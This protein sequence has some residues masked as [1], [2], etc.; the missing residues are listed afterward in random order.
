VISN[1][2]CKQSAQ[3]P[4]LPQAVFSKPLIRD[5]IEWDQYPGRLE[6]PQVVN[7]SARVSGIIE[8]A[9]F[10]EGSLVAAGDVLFVIDERPFRADL[11]SREADVLAAQAQLAQSQAHFLRYQKLKGTKAISAEDYDE[12]LAAL[13]QAKSRIAVAEAAR[14]ISKLNLEWT[15]VVAPITGRIS[16]KYVTEGN[17]ITGGNGQATLL[18]TITSVDPMYC[19]ANAPERALLRY[20]EI[21]K[22]REQSGTKEPLPCAIKLENEDTFKHAGVINFVDNRIDT[23]TGTVD[24]RCS[25]PNPNGELVS[26]LFA[27]LQLPGSL[28]YRALLI[29]DAAVGTDQ[30]SR[31]VL[32]VGEGDT[33]ARK[34]IIL[35]ALFGTLRSVVKGVDAEDKV[36]VTGLQNLRPGVKVAPQETPIG[37]VPPSALA[38]GER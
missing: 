34:P 19:Y 38:S 13:Q 6:S 3:P 16:R 26:G 5:V 7:L 11:Q 12:A 36:I 25:I 24:V 29:P 32:V 17:L 23:G 8:H 9:P 28:P 15:K 27:R 21:A 33:V 35:G 14:D 2:G 4:T 18:T 1:D 30:D 20:K 22:Q 10:Q 31:F 37:D